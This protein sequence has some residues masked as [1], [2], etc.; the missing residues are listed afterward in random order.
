[1]IARVIARLRC[2]W[3]GHDWAAAIE[4]HFSDGEV[5]IEHRCRRCG[6]WQ[7]VID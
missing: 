4:T 5:T 2:L 1:M 3:L 7:G 6:C